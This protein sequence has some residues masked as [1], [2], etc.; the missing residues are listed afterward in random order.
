M[1]K[2]LTVFGLLFIFLLGFIT[3]APRNDV[4][5]THTCG[6]CRDGTIPTPPTECPIGDGHGCSC[7]CPDVS[8]GVDTCPGPCSGGGGNKPPTCTVSAPNACAGQNQ[9]FSA[10]CQDDT[11]LDKMG[12]YYRIPGG[13]WQELKGCTGLNGVKS[14]TCSIDTKY[15]SNLPISQLPQ[16]Y[17]VVVNGW[18]TGGLKCSGNK[19]VA[20]YSE[21]A[22]GNGDNKTITIDYCPTPPTSTPTQLSCNSQCSNINDLC[23]AGLSC[24]GVTL[25]GGSFEFRCR[26]PACP[27]E[28][29]CICRTVPTP[30]TPPPPSLS[31][32]P[33]IIKRNNRIISPSAIKPGDRL[34]FTASGNAEPNARVIVD[35]RVSVPRRPVWSDTKTGNANN[36]GRYSITSAEYTAVAGKHTV[37]A[38]AHY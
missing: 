1:K 31:C 14:Y 23:P 8:G 17:Q 35:F 32:N 33:I 6:Y 5:A 21:C 26:K 4:L 3:F 37:R 7:V 24:L 25:P 34:T 22:S 20:G 28:S 16:D 27:S 30:I 19:P 18:D 36:N 11:G 12:I 29:D 38:T 2:L 10:T 15:L 9:H 13:T